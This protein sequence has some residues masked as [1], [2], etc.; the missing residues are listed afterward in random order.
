MKRVLYRRTGKRNLV[1]RVSEIKCVTFRFFFLLSKDC[2]M[3]M[4]NHLVIPMKYLLLIVGICSDRAV[5]SLHFRQ[6][7]FTYFK[8]AQDKVSIL[9]GYSIAPLGDW[10]LMFWDSLVVPS[11]KVQW[12]QWTFNSWGWDHQDIPK[13]QPA[14]THLCSTISL[15]D[16]NLNCTTTKA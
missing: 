14:V 11:E 1:N 7:C 2:I 8:L 13:C 6:Y 16:G 5:S 10:C 4:L 12:H 9:L 15:K 3:K